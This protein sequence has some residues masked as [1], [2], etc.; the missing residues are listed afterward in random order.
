VGRRTPTGAELAYRPD[1]G[2]TGRLLSLVAAEADCCPDLRLDVTLTLRI[3]AP[4]AMRDWVGETFVP[5]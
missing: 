1:P 5:G 2:V 4:A 3:E